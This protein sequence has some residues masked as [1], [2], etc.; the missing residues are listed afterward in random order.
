MSGEITHELQKSQFT[1]P[2]ISVWHTDVMQ[3]TTCSASSSHGESVREQPLTDDTATATVTATTAAENMAFFTKFIAPLYNDWQPGAKTGR[4]HP[5]KKPFSAPA[6]GPDRMCP[7]GSKK[8]RKIFHKLHFF[9]GI[10]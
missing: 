6:G 3:M 2:F 7:S 4:R 5:F 9:L 1:W 8:I 10:R